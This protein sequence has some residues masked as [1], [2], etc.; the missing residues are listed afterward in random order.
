MGRAWP[1]THTLCLPVCNHRFACSVYRET[2]LAL[3]FVRPR[4]DTHLQ[5][6]HSLTQW[7]QTLW[8]QPVTKT[9][10]WGHWLFFFSCLPISSPSALSFLSIVIHLVY[11]SQFVLTSSFCLFPLDVSTGSLLVNVASFVQFLSVILFFCCDREPRVFLNLLTCSV[12]SKIK[13]VWTVVQQS[14]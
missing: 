11:H 5:L 7:W 6:S 3:Y 14:S 12:R 1:R 4:E 8:V 9:I 2:T 13:P 10:T